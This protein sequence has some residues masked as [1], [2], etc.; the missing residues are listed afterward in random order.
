MNQT[1]NP[2]PRVRSAVRGR[3]A[4]FLD[5][6]A[7]VSRRRVVRLLVLVLLASGLTYA[8][9]RQRP[10]P[11]PDLPDVPLG[12]ADP[13]VVA[14]VEAA[15]SRVRREPHS[16][17][18]W[19]FLGEV[20]LVHGYEPQ[21]ATCFARAAQLNDREARWP[22]FQAQALT[23]RDGDAR[24]RLLERAVVLCDQQDPKVTAPRLNLAEALL[25]QG[26][27]DEAEQQLN[28]VAA[29]E[30]KSAHLTYLRGV[31]AF[32]RNDLAAAEKCFTRVAE[33]AAGRKKAA[34][35]LAR[36]Y[37]ALNQPEKAA[38][39]SEKA[40][41]APADEPWADPYVNEYINLG[42]G[43]Q[44]KL[45]RA[46][47]LEDAGRTG[48]AASVLEEVARDSPGEVSEF[49]VAANL[50]KQGRYGEAVEDLRKFLASHPDNPQARYTLG[51]D[52]YYQGALLLQKGAE[53]RA[54]AA[55]K[56]RE[57]ADVC[58]QLV[59]RKRDHAFG[60]LFLGRS[61]LQLD[62]RKGAITALRQAVV[63]RPEVPGAHLYLGLA[64]KADGQ[65]AEARKHL[66]TALQADPGDA[67]AHQTLA[68]GLA[69]AGQYEE[70]R[71]HLEAARKA[72]PNDP[73]LA[74]YFE[75]LQAEMSR[76]K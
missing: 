25:Q 21:A 31:L 63:L 74:E 70:A 24:L 69:A 12:K 39:A 38:A 22:Y 43:R 73:K 40:R 58:R 49:A 9:Y 2:W 10:E 57:A 6:L 50:S 13:P 53:G 8:W 47:L 67:R 55:A 54:E 59:E 76:P 37:Q 26:R 11:P 28:T 15:M 62:D 61:L 30:P 20:L 18:A 4:L 60:Y 48:E 72:Q 65:E 27:D 1:L 23:N 52:L 71:K 42:V 56:F 5:R 51:M 17:E 19:G 7:V 34:A 45:M 46:H 16:D 29:R 14:A 32:R 66:D 36:I 35:Q 33:H 3:L 68:A 41:T 64:L 44:H 75:Q